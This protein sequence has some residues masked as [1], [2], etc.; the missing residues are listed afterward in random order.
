[1]SRA[2]VDDYFRRDADLMIGLEDASGDLI[3]D[4]EILF[5]GYMDKVDITLAQGLGTMTMS[6]ESRGTKFLSSSDRRYTDEDKQAEVTGDLF[7]EY[8][9]R[10]I[11]LQLRWG[12]ATMQNPLPNLEGGRDPVTRGA[13]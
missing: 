1:M 12:D 13:R 3:A 8:I 6:L 5:S 4:P 2:L 11:D 9:Y 10:M 7:A